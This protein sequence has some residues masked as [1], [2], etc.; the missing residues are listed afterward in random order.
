M[1]PRMTENA[2]KILRAAFLYHRSRPGRRDDRTT[3]RLMDSL[4]R[5]KKHS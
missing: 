1:K 5:Y 2:E 3:V 4:V